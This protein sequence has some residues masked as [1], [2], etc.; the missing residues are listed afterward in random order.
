MGSG[1]EWRVFVGHGYEVERV[2]VWHGYEVERVFVGHGYEVERRYPTDLSTHLERIGGTWLQFF[3][4]GEG[5]AERWR[6]LGMYF[7]LSVPHLRS[8]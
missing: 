2:F 3:L 7:S 5:M 6:G 4:G 1:V 8:H